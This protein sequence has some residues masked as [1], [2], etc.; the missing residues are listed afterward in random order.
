MTTNISGLRPPP[1][2]LEIRHPIFMA[3]SMFKQQRP[4]GM[5][6]VQESLETGR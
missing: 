3:V 6:R 1:N 4:A 5:K 2:R